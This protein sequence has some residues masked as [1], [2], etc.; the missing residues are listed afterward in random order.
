MYLPRFHREFRS[1]LILLKQSS[2]LSCL[3]GFSFLVWLF[4]FFPFLHS[5]R[6]FEGKKIYQK[7]LLQ[8]EYVRHRCPLGKDLFNQSSKLRE[9]SRN[10]TGKWLSGVTMT[11]ILVFATTPGWHSTVA[12][13]QSEN[14]E[15]EQ[16]KAAEITSAFV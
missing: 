15:K 14:T 6:I 16:L 11:R 7:L 13:K 8:K 12:L 5:C 4:F 3:V 10:A 1:H 9:L 2:P